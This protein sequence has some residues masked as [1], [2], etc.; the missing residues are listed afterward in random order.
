MTDPDRL[1]RGFR[2]LAADLATTHRLG[3]EQGEWLA[4]VHL[5]VELVRDGVAPSEL[6]VLEQLA[7][8]LDDLDI[9]EAATGIAG[10]AGLRVDDAHDPSVHALFEAVA[11]RAPG[12]AG[13]HV[14]LARSWE[15]VGDVCALERG[16]HRALGLD[17]D[18]VAAHGDL[19]ELAALRGRFRAASRHLDRAG[20][21]PMGL[22]AVAGNVG[23]GPLRAGR[24]D[25]CP[26]GSGVRFKRCCLETDGW[27]LDVRVQLLP[28]RLANWVDRPIWFRRRLAFADAV[29]GEEATADDPDRSLDAALT[30]GMVDLY[31]FDGGGL[32]RLLDEVAPVLRADE[33]DVLARWGHCRHDLYEVLGPTAAGTR[34]AHVGTGE[35][36]DVAGL[37]RDLLEGAGSVVLAALAPGAP[38]APRAR[39]LA[40]GPIPI[41][42]ERTEEVRRIVD[43]GND[44]VALA[45]AAITPDIEFQR[46]VRALADRHD[47]GRLERLRWLFG[48][49]IDPSCVRDL[50]DVDDLVTTIYMSGGGLSSE[51]E[52]IRWVARQIAEGEPPEVWTTAQELTAAGH[53]RQSVLVHLACAWVVAAQRGPDPDDVRAAH[54]ENLR[55]VPARAATDRLGRR[56]RRSP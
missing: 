15:A 22:A 23:W 29:V 45:R 20:R 19:G 41:G 13:V 32:R 1:L 5:A 21:P 35:V 24:N 43:T 12:I 49:R 28:A 4:L 9:L 11:D 39:V 54:L 46:A 48:D 30:P 50:G 34:L 14:A 37:D 53:D 8:A 3:D 42:A 10:V 6:P 36:S 44:P 18:H 7:L 52:H 31:L 51:A 25:P 40:G 56:E 55:S 17:P 2:R 38:T 26:C 16:L 27:P 47:P 33:R